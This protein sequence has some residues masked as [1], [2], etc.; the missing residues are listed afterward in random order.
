M[1]EGKVIGNVKKRI[2]REKEN[3]IKEMMNKFRDREIIKEIENEKGK[4]S[5]ERVKGIMIKNEI[6]RGLKIEIKRIRKSVIESEKKGRRKIERNEENEGEIGKVRSEEDLYDG[7]IKENIRRKDC[8]ERRILGKIDDE[9]MIVGK[10]KI[11]IGENNEKNLE[12]ENIEERKSEV[13]K[14]KIIERKEKKKKKKRERIRREEEEMKRIE[15]ESIE[16]KK[17]KIVG[18]GMESWSKKNWNSEG[19][20]GW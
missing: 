10:L 15:V 14:G 18:I 8:E 19:N 7:I 4:K 17:M 13:E 12:K 20:E 16:D 1:I 3:G 6:E 2:D 5:E 9:I 11:E